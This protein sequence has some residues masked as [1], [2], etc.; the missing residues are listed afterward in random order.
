MASSDAPRFFCDAML[1]KLCKWLRVAGFDAAYAR[2]SIPIQL[3]DKARREGRILLTRNTKVASR[4]NLPPHM[5][6]ASDSWEDQLL[7]VARTFGL[8][9]T[10]EAFARCLACNVELVPVENR[11]DVETVVPEYVYRRV[12]EFHQCP[13][14][15]KVFWEGTHIGRMAERLS[16]V[17]R[18]A[19]GGPDKSS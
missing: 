13:A 1:G 9:L 11:A 17:A 10:S 19:G 6:L 5:F 14:C 15:G 8:E 4:E 3:V 12:A 2:R 18:R 16:A 7:E